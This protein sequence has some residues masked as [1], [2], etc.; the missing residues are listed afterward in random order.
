[1][2]PVELAVAFTLWISFGAFL[3]FPTVKAP[4]LF[5][6]TAIA[7]CAAELA[8]CVLMTAGK[9][10]IAP[11]CPSMAVAAR[12]AASVDIPALT[13]LMLVLAAAY[14]LRVARTW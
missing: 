7:L 10:C 8:A 1:M 4:P 13:G 6:R 11:G 9:T 5:G 2:N 14:G 3:F 12:T